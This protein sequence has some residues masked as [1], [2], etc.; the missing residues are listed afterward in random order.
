MEN[1]KDLSNKPHNGT[2][3]EMAIEIDSK[4]WLL[5][6]SCQYGTANELIG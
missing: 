1:K 5:L 4:K 3:D 2:V 6:L